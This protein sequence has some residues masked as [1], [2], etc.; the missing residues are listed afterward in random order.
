MTEPPASNPVLWERF[1]QVLRDAAGAAKAADQPPSGAC[2]EMR[3]LVHHAESLTNADPD[4]FHRSALAIGAHDCDQW[5]GVW[6]GVFG[7]CKV[8]ADVIH[9]RRDDWERDVGEWLDPQARWDPSDSPPSAVPPYAP[10]PPYLPPSPASSAAPVQPVPH[11]SQPQ[12]GSWPAGAHD[13]LDHALHI[14]TY[15]GA[16]AAGGVIGNR[17][18]AGVVAAVKRLL[19]AMRRRLPGGRGAEPPLGR[20]EAIESACSAVYGRGYLGGTFVAVRADRE[21]DCWI[22]HCRALHLETGMELMR[23]RVPFADAASPSILLVN[24]EPG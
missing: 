21:A 15:V 6:A 20:E 13:I 17:A 19:R 9:G 23:V 18:D 8:Y 3:M 7:G 5:H 22:V 14:G 4:L 2:G 12:A 1:L 24:R 11:P 16:A 10:Q